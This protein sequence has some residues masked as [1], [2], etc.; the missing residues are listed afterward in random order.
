VRLP[1]PHIPPQV[2]R[3]SSFLAAKDHASTHSLCCASLNPIPQAAPTARLKVSLR[4][5]LSCLLLWLRNSSRQL[6]CPASR[7]VQS[8]FSALHFVSF[9]IHHSCSLRLGYEATPQSI[10]H[11]HKLHSL[12]TRGSFHSIPFR[13]FLIHSASCRPP[14]AIV[15]L[16]CACRSGCGLS[17]FLHQRIVGRLT[18]A[19]F[20]QP[21]TH[22]QK[23]TPAL[24]RAATARLIAHSVAF[25]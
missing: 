1:P 6:L 3:C 13:S 2:I 16:A 14:A 23:I 4:S 10:A 24:V 15:V 5:M 21:T 25:S 12:P 17:C 9:A 8:S 7:F 22:K 18:S 11:N 20:Q 19:S